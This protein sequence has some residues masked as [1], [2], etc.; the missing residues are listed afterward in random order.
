MAT[1]SFDILKFD[2]T[3]CHWDYKIFTY[4][5]WNYWHDYWYLDTDPP[6]LGSSQ[7]IVIKTMSY[8]FQSNEMLTISYQGLW[9]QIFIELMKFLIMNSYT[10][11]QALRIPMK[12]RFQSWYHCELNDEILN[13]EFLLFVQKPQNITAWTVL[14]FHNLRC[15]WQ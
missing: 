12:H 13:Y 11:T 4:S 3:F 2:L 5:N 14:K 7:F 6:L 8:I 1:K 15:T 10:R 9:F